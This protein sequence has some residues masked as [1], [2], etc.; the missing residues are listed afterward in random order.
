MLQ[1]QEEYIEK[2][3]D[4]ATL[5]HTVCD[6]TFSDSVCEDAIR[7]ECL[8]D[9]AIFESDSSF[10]AENSTANITKEFAALDSILCSTVNRYDINH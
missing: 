4:Y 6:D 9:F 10:E 5:I 7:Q 8:E 1:E 2:D 3:D